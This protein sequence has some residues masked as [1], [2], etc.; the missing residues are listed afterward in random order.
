MPY[1]DLITG[2]ASVTVE[3]ETG[4]FF[5]GVLGL[6]GGDSDKEDPLVVPE[7]VTDDTTAGFFDWLSSTSEPAAAASTGSD[8]PLLETPLGEVSVPAST[9]QAAF[10]IGAALAVGYVAIKAFSK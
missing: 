1:Q 4:G 8:V 5:S 9:A 6:F 7:P 3:Q 2:H 10:K